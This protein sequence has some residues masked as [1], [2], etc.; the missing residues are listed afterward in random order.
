M[1]VASVFVVVVLVALSLCGCC[2]RC[3]VVMIVVLAVLLLRAVD[4]AFVIAVMPKSIVRR[5]RRHVATTVVA[6]VAVATG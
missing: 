3:G 1:L 4:T 6:A 5:C 2:D